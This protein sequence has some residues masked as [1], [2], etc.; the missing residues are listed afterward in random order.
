MDSETNPEQSQAEESPQTAT[1]ETITPDA[2]DP[3]E[4][5]NDQ[6][7]VAETDP[8]TTGEGH[9]EPAAGQSE[10]TTEDKTDSSTPENAPENKTEDSSPPEE[11]PASTEES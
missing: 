5:A 3:V 2:A 8:S 4:A 11:A 10:N 9:E 7:E 6:A 1:D